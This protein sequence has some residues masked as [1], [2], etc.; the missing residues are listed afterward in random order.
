MK[1]KRIIGLFATFILVQGIPSCGIYSFTGT[2]IQPDVKT[3]TINY[4][5][6]KAMKVNPSLSNEL[7]EAL[8]D[9]FKK[10]TRLE[11]VEEDGDLEFSGQ[12]TGYEIRATAITADEYAAQNRLTV[13]VKIQFENRKADTDN[14]DKTFSAYADYSSERTLDEV[15]A[16]LCAEIIE[17]LVE[18]IFNAS[19]AQW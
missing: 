14:F 17:K 13:N 1:L 5:E 10:M 15:E 3:F 16:A 9:R 8:R 12:I 6:N 11:E 19:V 4:I 2:S 7:T 18:E